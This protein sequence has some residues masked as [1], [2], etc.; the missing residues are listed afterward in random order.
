MGGLWPYPCGTGIAN[1]YDHAHRAWIFRKLLKVSRRAAAVPSFKLQVSS[2]KMRSNCQNVGRQPPKTSF[3]AG[4]A[5][6]MPAFFKKMRASRQRSQGFS[7]VVGRMSN[8]DSMRQITDTYTS[9]RR[10]PKTRPL[11]RRSFLAGIIHF[12]E[13]R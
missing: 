9:L 10:I 1:P 13:V 2:F 8:D 5:G 12:S 6:I 4:S 3:F 7:E 11:C